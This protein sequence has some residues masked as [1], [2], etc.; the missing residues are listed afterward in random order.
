MDTNRIPKQALWYRPKG[1]RNIGRPK[2]RWR[3]QLHFEDSVT[4]NAPNP[5]RTWWWLAFQ[6]PTQPHRHLA[7]AL[8]A[9]LYVFFYLPKI[10]KPTYF[11]QLR[12]MV[13]LPSPNTVAVCNHII[14]LILYYEGCSSRTGTFEFIK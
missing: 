11:E 1:R 10:T 4:G 9:L 5:S 3:N 8:G 12:E 14:L 6:L 2:K 13:P 7:Q